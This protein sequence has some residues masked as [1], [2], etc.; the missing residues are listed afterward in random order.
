M[1]D[2]VLRRSEIASRVCV[3]EGCTLVSH[4]FLC[5]LLE[6]L[7]SCVDVGALGEALCDFLSRF[8]SDMHVIRTQLSLVPVDFVYEKEEQ[9]KPYK[10]PQNQVLRWLVREGSRISMDSVSFPE[11]VLPRSRF[12]VA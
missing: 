9:Y 8:V 6:C 5:G 4:T 7:D 12:R 11:S 10:S 2:F 1:S 3:C